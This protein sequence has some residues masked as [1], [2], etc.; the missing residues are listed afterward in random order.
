MG[1]IKRYSIGEV[2]LTRLFQ[3]EE[4]LPAETLDNLIAELKLKEQ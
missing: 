3:R 2:T 1:N 4:K